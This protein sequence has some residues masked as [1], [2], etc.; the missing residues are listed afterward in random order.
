MGWGSAAPCWGWKRLNVFHRPIA[1]S[2]LFSPVDVQWSPPGLAARRRLFLMLTLLWG[3][4][5]EASRAAAGVEER[6]GMRGVA[7]NGISFP[8]A[9]VRK[10][11]S[12]SE[13]LLHPNNKRREVSGVT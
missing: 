7:K 4:E 13:D 8:R 2:N 12:F 11:D 1:A 5:S 10:L 3:A 9:G 6:A